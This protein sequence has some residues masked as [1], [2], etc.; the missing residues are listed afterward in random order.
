MFGRILGK[1]VGTP[2]RIINAPVKIIDKTLEALDP[3]DDSYDMN[4]SIKRSISSLEDFIE[5]SID[6]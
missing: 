4:G 3:L 1:V 5:D 6:D 2:L